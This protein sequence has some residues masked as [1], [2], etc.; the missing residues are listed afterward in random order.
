MSMWSAQA[1][2]TLGNCHVYCCACDWTAALE[3]TNT[4]KWRRWWR[5]GLNIVKREYS[6]HVRKVV[7]GVVGKWLCDFSFH[8]TIVTKIIFCCVITKLGLDVIYDFHFRVVWPQISLVFLDQRFHLRITIK[9]LPD[10]ALKWGVVEIIPQAMTSDGREDFS[11]GSG[12]RWDKFPSGKMVA[13]KNQ[14][15]STSTPLFSSLLKTLPDPLG[16]QHY[17]H[18]LHC[19]W[20]SDDLALW[21][22]LWPSWPPPQNH[23]IVGNFL[24][25]G[26]CK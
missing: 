1:W 16:G 15:S 18:S 23:A 14:K 4:L 21:L 17:S 24:S 3:L 10:N 26:V 2:E 22:Q 11:Q 13:M 20:V 9:I 5:V 6:P 25:I 8:W 12:G 7:Q 19:Q